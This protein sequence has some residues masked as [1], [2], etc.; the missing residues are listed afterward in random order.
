M[1]DDLKKAVRAT[2]LSLWDLSRATGLAVVPAELSRWLNGKSC[3]GQNKLDALAAA[4][5]VSVVKRETK[6][7]RI[8]RNRRELAA[9]VS[10]VEPSRNADLAAELLSQS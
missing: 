6:S 10:A 4:A 2:G 1:I 8:A 9:A 3:L 7:A 5:G